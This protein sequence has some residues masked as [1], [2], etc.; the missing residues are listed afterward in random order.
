MKP[1][2][3]RSL[4]E[5]MGETQVEFA[6][7]LHIEQ[8]ALSKLERGENGPAG[9]TLELL[10]QLQGAMRPG[11][12]QANGNTDI[13]SGID[14]LLE[15][16]RELSACHRRLLASQAGVQAAILSFIDREPDETGQWIVRG[17]GFEA[18]V[19][20]DGAGSVTVEIS[21]RRPVASTSR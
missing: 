9:P 21:P 13:E 11:G 7:R 17:A 3:I 1:S 19:T 6:R 12:Q 15:A 4:R 16:H 2:E 20:I 18:T 5:R 8:S 10:R 14:R